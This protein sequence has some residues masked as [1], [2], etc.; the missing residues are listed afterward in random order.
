MSYIASSSEQIKVFLYACG[1]GFA[2]GLFYELF[3]F[4][5][6]IAKLKKKGTVICDFIYG[7]FS[8]IMLFVFSL[9]VNNGKFQSYYYIGAFF[10][11]MVYYYSFGII[12]IKIIGLVWN[13]IRRIIAFFI[14]MK[15]FFRK[16]ILQKR[17][18]IKKIQK[19]SKDTIAS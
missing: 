14:R 6:C 12:S 1:F 18:K 4:L 19:N 16:N 2:L 11:W 13:G 17:K 9:A 8:V 7:F 10:G 15:N 3:T 5:R